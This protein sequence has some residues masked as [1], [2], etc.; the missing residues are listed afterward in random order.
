MAKRVRKLRCPIC[1]NQ[2]KDS[3]PEF[4][5]CSARCRTIDLGRWASD[6]YVVSTPM[7][8]T[9]EGAPRTDP[10]STGSDDD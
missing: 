9:D 2:V 5:F 10:G 6:H 3:D 4:P 7:R 1:R 8:D